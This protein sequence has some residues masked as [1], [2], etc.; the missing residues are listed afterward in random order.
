MMIPAYCRVVTARFGWR[1]LTNSQLYR[2]H[3][4]VAGRNLPTWWDRRLAGVLAELM[5]AGMAPMLSRHLADACRWLG[6]AFK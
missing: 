3:S 5:G 2:G 6:L 1:F 4:M